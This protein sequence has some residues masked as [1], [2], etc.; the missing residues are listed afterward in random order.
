M[1]AQLGLPAI[2]ADVRIDYAVS[3]LDNIF[4]AFEATE[5][6][7]LIRKDGIQFKLASGAAASFRRAM[8]NDEFFFFSS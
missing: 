7:S 3:R 1:N 4:K 8:R 2:F 5:L 6:I